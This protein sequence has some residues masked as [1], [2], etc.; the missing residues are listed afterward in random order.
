MHWYWQLKQRA[1]NCHANGS[2]CLNRHSGPRCRWNFFQVHVEVD[3][4]QMLRNIGGAHHQGDQQ[5]VAVVPDLHAEPI[6]IGRDTQRQE[7]LEAAFF[8]HQ[9]QQVLAEQTVAQALADG[10]QPW[11]GLRC[12]V[13]TKSCWCSYALAPFPIMKKMMERNHAENGSL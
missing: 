5:R 2:S 9:L 12:K 13:P 1:A 7:G 4:L 11:Q 6:G 8:R 3:L 10:L